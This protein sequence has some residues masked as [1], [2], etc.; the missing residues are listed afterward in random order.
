MIDATAA[1]VNVVFLVLRMIPRSARYTTAT[2][3]VGVLERR[4]IVTSSRSDVTYASAGST[5]D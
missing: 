3:F 5:L 4:S 2:R 1:I